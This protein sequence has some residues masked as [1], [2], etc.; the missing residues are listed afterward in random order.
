[1]R[2]IKLI[3]AYDGTAYHGFQIQKGTG[4]RTVQEELEKALGT[5]TGEDIAVIGSG[6]TDAGV[7]AQGQVISFTCNSRIPA[8]RFPLALNSLL[9][10]D[11]VAWEACEVPPD[12]HARFSAKGKTYKYTIY[13]HRHLSPFWRYYAYHVPVSLDLPLMV[14]G[15]KHFL[16]THDFRGFCAKDTAVKD[17]VRTIFK[18]D[19]EKAGPFLTVTVS[20]DGFLYN[21]IRIMVGTLL[22]IG[23]GKRAPEEIPFLLEAGERKLSGVTLPPQGLCLWSVQY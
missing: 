14:Q 19:V 4:L 20:G 18:C 16:G 9:P 11:I 17:Y 13:N 1:M 6:R 8:E 22:E 12:F 2:N 3:L 15:S 5:L 21:M 7:H 10:R 23:L